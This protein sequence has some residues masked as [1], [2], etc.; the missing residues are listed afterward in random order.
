M[1]KKEWTVCPPGKRERASDLPTIPELGPY[2]SPPYF[3][4]F[5]GDLNTRPNS[6]VLV[7]EK[8]G[9]ETPLLIKKKKKI[10]YCAFLGKK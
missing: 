2:L 5:F 1:G 3:S 6:L 9:Y 7:K 10:A 4:P 8:R